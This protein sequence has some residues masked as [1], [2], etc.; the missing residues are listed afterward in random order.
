[1]LASERNPGGK[2]WGAEEEGGRGGGVFGMAVSVALDVEK[3]RVA[4]GLA[5]PPGAPSALQ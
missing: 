2:K 4:S 5:E 1:M 3:G